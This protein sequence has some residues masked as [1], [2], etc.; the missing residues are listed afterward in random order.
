MDL[1]TRSR[2]VALVHERALRA[3]RRP[4]SEP[5]ID[6]DRSEGSSVVPTQRQLPAEPVAGDSLA[7][8]TMRAIYRAVE[9]REP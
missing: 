6:A 2:R 8:D 9:E 4:G 1:I 5:H 3:A 7:I